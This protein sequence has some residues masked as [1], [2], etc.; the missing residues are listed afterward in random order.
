MMSDD[1]PVRIPLS[2]NDKIITIQSRFKSKRG[3]ELDTKQVVDMVFNG[4]DLE[5]LFKGKKGRVLVKEECKTIKVSTMT[6][7]TVKAIQEGLK[8]TCDK[9]WFLKDIVAYVF[10]NSD[11]DNIFGLD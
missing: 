8:A 9:K 5:K 11:L 10:N 3:T 2:I 1:L 6:Y 4:A 7:G